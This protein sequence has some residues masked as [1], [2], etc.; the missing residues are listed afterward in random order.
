MLKGGD[1]Y[2]PWPWEMIEL[3]CERM[4]SRLW[5]FVALALYTGQ[6][7]GDVLA[8]TWGSIRGD[9]IAVRQ[10]KTDKPLLLPIHRDLRPVLNAIPRKGDTILLN[11]RGQPWTGDGF[12]ASWRKVVPKEIKDRELVLHGLRKS[13]VCLL[14]EAG[15]TDAEVGAVTGQSRE[16]VAHYSRQ[17]NQ[18]KLAAAALLKWEAIQATDW[19]TLGNSS[20]R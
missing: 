6:R 20:A 15:A 10:E 2:E 5:W 3:A 1:P 18:T 8:M 11:E 4:P 17:V 19:E 14:L 12:S 7:R 13:A 9:M 16:M